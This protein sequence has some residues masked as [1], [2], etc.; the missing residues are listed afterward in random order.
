[1]T[2]ACRADTA[3]SQRIVGVCLGGRQSLSDSQPCIAGGK[4]WGA[5]TIGSQNI[6]T[7]G[8]GDLYD[9][10]HIGQHGGTA[11]EC[12]GLPPAFARVCGYGRC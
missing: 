11:F 2:A 6:I 1:M 12:L 8:A 10:Q 9:C 7:A 3:D 5:G 4:H